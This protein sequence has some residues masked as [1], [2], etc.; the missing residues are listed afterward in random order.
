MN[1]DYNLDQAQSLIPPFYP[2]NL[3]R[4]VSNLPIALLVDIAPH[5]T[6]RLSTSVKFYLFSRLQQDLGLLLKIHL[7]CILLQRKT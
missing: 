7:F 2:S 4:T 6:I 5:L 1:D 3:L